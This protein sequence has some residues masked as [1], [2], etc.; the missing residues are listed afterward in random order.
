MTKDLT[1]NQKKIIAFYAKK[2]QLRVEEI[3]KRVE[4][5]VCTI[6]ELSLGIL[7]EKLQERFL[8]KSF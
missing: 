1:Y 8:K 2:A 3:T 4:D 5:G 7:G 6:S